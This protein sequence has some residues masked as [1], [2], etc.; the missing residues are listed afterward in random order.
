MFGTTGFRQEQPFAHPPVLA[1][2]D[3]GRMMR[4]GLQSAEA[5][6]EFLLTADKI[7][8]LLAQERSVTELIIFAVGKRVN[9]H[10]LL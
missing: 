4:Y 1:R 8:L 7:C 10:P 9:A 3:R 6:Q 5:F 2:N